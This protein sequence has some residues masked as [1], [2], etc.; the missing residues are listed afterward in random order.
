MQS[1]RIRTS[2]FG[3]FAFILFCL[4]AAAQPSRITRRIDDGDRIS[5][6]GH[7][8]PKALPDYDQGR[9]A[10]S[11]DLSYVSLVLA[12][13]AAQQAD[14]ENLLVQQ[15]TPGSPNFHRWLSPEDFGKRF[16]PSD[17]D[18]AQIAAWLQNQGMKVTYVARG[19]EWIAFDATA[20]QAEAAFGTELHQYLVNGELHFANA[21]APSIPSA[22]AGVVAG[23]RGLH[24]FRPHPRAIRKSVADYTSANGTHYVAPNDI[25]TI[26]DIA[27]L[28]NAGIDGSGQK[29]AVAGQ[30]NISLSDIEQFRSTFGLPAND[31]Q[32]VLVPGSRNPGIVSGDVDESHLDLEW[33]GA[34]ARNAQ[35]IYIYAPDVSTSEQYAIDQNIAPVLSESYGGCEPETFPADATAMRSLAQQANAQGVTWFAPSG[36]NGAADCNDAQNPGLAVD[37][38]AAIPEVTGVGGTQFDE[39]VG[40]YWNVTNDATGASARSYIPEAAWNDSALEGQPSAS[41]G[42]AS[43]FFA[44]PSWQTVAG[45][46][47]DNARHVPDIALN[48]S[49]SHDAYITYSSGR[50]FVGGTSAGVPIYAAIATLLNQYLV[51]T[52]A[53]S[54]PGL[55]NINPN[56]YALYQ[57]VPEAFHD[58]TTGNNIV[59][60]ACPV[61]S[62][63]GCAATPVGYS[64]GPGYDQV[65]GLGSVD[66]YALI[67]NWTRAGAVSGTSSVQM[68]LVPSQTTVAAGD[69]VDL[70]ATV[71]DP[72]GTTPSGTVVFTS[73][74]A[75]L[76]SV[77]LTGSGMTA[78]ATLTVNGSQIPGGTIAASYTGPS[79]N[80]TATASVVTS[81]LARSS[82]A[83]PNIAALINGASFRQAHAPGGVATV[84]G[85]Q[86]SQSTQAAG[87]V[88]LPVSMA[89]VTVT[90]NG[91]IAPLYYAS[92]TQVNFQIPYTTP[93][94]T[95]TVAINNDGQ[96][97]SQS[98]TISALAPGIFTDQNGVLVPSGSASS[99]QVISLYFTGAGAIS[100]ALSTGS[101]PSMQAQ[102]ASLPRPLQMVGV[103]VA[104]VSA[105]IQFA[106]DAPGLV[107]VIQVNFQVPGGV[108]TGP[109]QVVV[110]VG[111]VAS[112]PVMLTIH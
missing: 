89:G 97:T 10:P 7:I 43:I 68:T 103:T 73:G 47:N 56:L 108:P 48:A 87:S 12:P 67:T 106:G 20:A 25:A 74:K 40:N 90:V 14:L 93:T 104:G 51:G 79:G 111:G 31:P 99:G 101:A 3:L 30:S 77:V 49:P 76:G 37:I 78:T 29:L 62:R 88:P 92:P 65:T 41:G 83:A 34:I 36:D 66:A 33:A 13:S 38:P 81:S 86:L 22:L 1:Q 53:Q 105:P 71:T 85:S 110:T 102:I 58:V 21:T 17:A 72:S 6:R 63:S 45:V 69:Q 4:A 44:K 18:I 15:R 52:G 59:T 75:V 28:Y 61:R 54:A 11:F 50:Q 57:A 96:V 84:F 98:I 24:D 46:P 32:V 35:I 94:G 82:N 100:P 64:A 16:G 109:Q 95:A 26:Y 80:Q 55:G 39:G 112:P 70:I 19:H 27:P 107:G 60:V 8:H 91:V 5:L 2:F 42:G 23:I 9:V